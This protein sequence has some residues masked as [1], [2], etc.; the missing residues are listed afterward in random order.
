MKIKFKENLPW[1]L[2]TGCLKETVAKIGVVVIVL[3][4]ADFPAEA[5]GDAIVKS[6]VSAEV[7][8]FKYLTF[9]AAGL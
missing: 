1:N 6:V 5:M 2:W 3:L 8:C 7:H 4:W 9:F